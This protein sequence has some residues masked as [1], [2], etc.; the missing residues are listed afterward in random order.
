MVQSSG[1]HVL[2][3]YEG[4]APIG[5]DWPK[6]CY[7]FHNGMAIYFGH[8]HSLVRTCG[9]GKCIVDLAA[10]PTAGGLSEVF[11]QCFRHSSH[12]YARPMLKQL[13]YPSDHVFLKQ[14]HLRLL[15]FDLFLLLIRLQGKVVRFWIAIMERYEAFSFHL[16]VVCNQGIDMPALP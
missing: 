5:L 4:A 10:L 15:S 11:S 13:K 7:C 9:R 2:L 16:D 1:R 14:T 6:D 3:F 12:Y 8:R